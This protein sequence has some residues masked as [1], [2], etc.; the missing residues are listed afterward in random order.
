MKTATERFIELFHVPEFVVPYLDSF[1]NEQEMAIIVAMEGKAMT[2][3]EL[4]GKLGITEGEALE[5][6]EQAYL[7]SVLNKDS[8]NENGY[9]SADFAA[10]LYYNCKFDEDYHKLPKDFRD[11][12]EDWSYGDYL[13]NVKERMTGE[14]DKSRNLSYLPIEELDEYLS[15]IKRFRIVPCDCRSLKDACE[16]PRETCIRFDDNIRDRTFGREITK[17]EAKEIIINAHKKGLMLQVNADWRETGA[18]GVCN[19]CACCCYPVRAALELNTKG[20]WP[21]VEYIATYDEN[22]CIHCGR[23]VK[24]CYFDVFTFSEEKIEVN[25]KIR[26]KIIYDPSKCWGCGLCATTCPTESIVMKRL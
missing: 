7:G 13:A 2:P 5:Q 1:V 4:A 19:C 23:C 9:I 25:G 24:R 8:E 15:G 14:I 26:K 6:M 17:E 3:R 22:T 11:E 18:T 16:R 20:K 21:L 10:K 12:I